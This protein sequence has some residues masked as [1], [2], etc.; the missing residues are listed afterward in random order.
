MVS[1]GPV[2]DLPVTEDLMANLGPVLDLPVTDVL[3][4]S[5]GQ[6]LPFMPHLPF[7]S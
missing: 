6:V 3:I 2:P 1:L 5:L 7:S 4:V